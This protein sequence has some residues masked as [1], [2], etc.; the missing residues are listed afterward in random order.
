MAGVRIRRCVVLTNGDGMDILSIYGLLPTGDALAQ[1]WAIGLS[2]QTSP[3]EGES[4]DGGGMRRYVVSTNGD[5]M[6][7]TSMGGFGIMLGSA[8]L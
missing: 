5:K 8:G 7:V 1:R 6:G 2:I 3:R 4:L